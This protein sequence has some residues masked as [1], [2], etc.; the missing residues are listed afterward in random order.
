METLAH[1][2]ELRLRQKVSTNTKYLTDFLKIY[3]CVTKE[4]KN[5]KNKNTNHI[6]EL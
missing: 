1:S 6:I 4:P 3:I 5:N 2:M